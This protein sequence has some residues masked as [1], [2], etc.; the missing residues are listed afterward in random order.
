MPADLY[1]IYLPLSSAEASWGGGGG[2][3]ED[4]TQAS[5]SFFLSSTSRIIPFYI[6]HICLP[7]LLPGHLLREYNHHLRPDYNNSLG[8]MLDMFNIYAF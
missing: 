7:S 5:N 3:G 2:V 1:I 8:A 6:T 4:K